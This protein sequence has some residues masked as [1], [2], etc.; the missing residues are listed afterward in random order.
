MP[1][2]Q[3]EFWKQ[4]KEELNNII[5]ASNF[6]YTDQNFSD[7]IITALQEL[8]STL[9]IVAHSDSTQLHFPDGTKFNPDSL[10]DEEKQSI[11]EN[12]PLIILLSCNTGTTTD[13]LSSFAQ[14]LL[15]TGPR[16]VIAP[17]TEISLESA[18]KLVDTYFQTLRTNPDATK[19]FWE[20][21]KKVFDN[22]G[23]VPEN[24]SLDEDDNFD[25]FFKFL[26][27]EPAFS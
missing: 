19:A 2:D 14:R 3:V 11:Y 7:E 26:V 5:R 18:N 25:Y 24:D 23:I 6:K 9:V 1:T 10:S 17:T 12:T 27:W 8:P 16:M 22:K 21:V 15:N 13:T 20:A 4:K